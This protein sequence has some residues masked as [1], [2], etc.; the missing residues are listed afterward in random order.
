LRT[1]VLHTDRSEVRTR[2]AEQKRLTLSIAQ[3]GQ[4]L[5]TISYLQRE[6]EQGTILFLVNHAK[7]QSYDAV[8]T[9][10]GG[11]SCVT[12]LTAEDGEMHPISYRIAEGNTESCLHFEPMG[13]HLLL[14]QPTTVSAYQVEEPQIQTVKME[15]NWTVERMDL[16]TLTLDYCSYRI[17]GGAVQGPIPVIKLQELLLQLQHPCS[18]ELYFEFDV[19]IDLDANREF[20]VVIEEAQLYEVSINGNSVSTQNLDWW[21]DKSFYKVSIKPYVQNGK[22]QLVL[23]TR[24]QQPQKVYDVLFGDDVYET[25]KNKITYEIEIEAIYLLGDFGVR[26]RNPYQKLAR[27]A[28]VTEGPF[29][30]VDAPTEF[31]TPD[32][33]TSG[34]L[35]FAGTMELSQI[36]SVKKEAGKKIVLDFGS[37]RAPLVKVYLNRSLIKDSMWAP[38][39]ADITD[40]V[41]EGDNLLT[42]QI[43]AS[44]RN[45]LGPHHHI[46]GE[47]YQVGPE[48]FTGK[49]S[50]VERRSEADATDIADQTKNYW[51][52]TYSFVEF[53][54]SET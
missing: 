43:F 54:F 50:W 46:D 11:S 17:D 49:W 42:I 30:V 45:L 23:T 25:E 3:H 18:L 1:C 8:L 24:F 12:A 36:L 53:G 52:D 44:N 26:S 16:N 6:T 13:S 19:D 29:V 5:E 2:L 22:N 27:G 20:C 14:L 41:A 15:A 47:C 7:D 39:C 28:M 9:V 33:T 38:Y 37:Q 40:A 4:E 34:L 31:R 51:T 21:K 48:S 35:F 10:Y 32:F